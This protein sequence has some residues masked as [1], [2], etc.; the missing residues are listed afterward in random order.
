MQTN[1]KEFSQ[2]EKAQIFK[3]ATHEVL[4]LALSLKGKEAT[5]NL[6]FELHQSFRKACN[7]FGTPS[8]TLRVWRDRECLTLSCTSDCIGIGFASAPVVVYRHMEVN[9]EIVCLPFFVRE[10]GKNIMIDYRMK[11]GGAHYEGDVHLDGSKCYVDLRSLTIHFDKENEGFAGNLVVAEWDKT[12]VAQDGSS[13]QKVGSGLDDNFLVSL[14]RAPQK[15]AGGKKRAQR[16]VDAEILPIFTAD[17]TVCVTY[18]RFLAAFSRRRG[19][20]LLFADYVR[21]VSDHLEVE[22]AQL[23]ELKK[24]AAV[25]ADAARKKSRAKAAARERKRTER[26]GTTPYITDGRGGMHPFDPTKVAAFK[27]RGKPMYPPPTLSEEEREARARVV[28]PKEVRS[29]A[30]IAAEVQSC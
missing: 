13:C 25:E 30:E 16:R 3:K 11:G 2:T 20:G 17:A 12:C 22:K 26:M 6:P 19:E 9:E 15:V 1:S 4:D 18:G 27:S 10:D 28:V 21:S 7:A 24:R 23:A 29:P 8:L 5:S 14:T